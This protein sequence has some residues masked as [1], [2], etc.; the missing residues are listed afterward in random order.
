[1]EYHVKIYNSGDVL[2][3]MTCSNFFHSAEL[4]HITER[5]IG[6]SPYMIVAFDENNNVVAHLLAI[7]RRRGSF[8]PPY[9]YTQGR[10]YGEGEY[11][12]EVDKSLVFNLM[13]RSATSKFKHKF[14][15]YV[16]FSN[17]SKK[18]LGYRFFRQNH[19]YPI[20]WQEIHNSLHSKKPEERISK[21]LQQRIDHI[22]NL[23]V[24]TR[25]VSGL[26]EVREFYKML[27][28]F[29]RFK[30]RRLIPSVR[31]FE[32]LY[33]SKNANIFVTTYKQK[34]I[35]GCTCVYSEGNAYLWYLASKRKSHPTLHPNT[36]TVWH[37]IKYAY[38]H[39]YAHIFFLDVGLPWKKNPFREFILSFGGKPIGMYRWFH[40]NIK[41]LNKILTWYYKE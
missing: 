8:L 31:H 2:P 11:N 6:S 19:Y 33:K 13:L 35:G 26:D 10:I 40:F 34:I 22:Y 17:L 41:W 5:V 38:E 14:C 30:F 12:D 36:M 7:I 29:Y 37:A 23:G 27:N 21:K 16:E 25:E 20:Q 28:K 24:E 4:F 18:M 1:M 39:N 32:E 9:L 15:F 3:E